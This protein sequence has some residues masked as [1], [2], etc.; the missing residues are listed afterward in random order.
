MTIDAPATAGV[1]LGCASSRSADNTRWSEVRIFRI[2][3]GYLA[4]RVGRSTV[5]GE[6]DLTASFGVADPRELVRWLSRPSGRGTRLPDVAAAAIAAASA[7]DSAFALGLAD[8]LEVEWYG[9]RVPSVGA[10]VVTLA[11]DG[12]RPVRFC[13]RIIGHAAARARRSSAASIFAVDDGTFAVAVTVDDVD[14]GRA[15]RRALAGLDA[16]G[17]VD[18]LRFRDGWTRVARRALRAAI[19]THERFAAAARADGAVHVDELPPPATILRDGPR[20]V[21]FVG[22]RIATA[23]TSAAD[24]TDTIALYKQHGGGYVAGVLTRT[25]ATAR[26]AP[27]VRAFE[28]AQQLVHECLAWAPRLL[29]AAAKVDL[30]VELALSARGGDAVAPAG[31]PTSAGQRDVVDELLQRD[32]AQR[33]AGLP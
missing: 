25:T 8:E 12:G 1:P 20:Q 7:A 13:G 31:V 33:V 14:D 15:R 29:A 5:P 11:R 19:A 16:G 10:Q 22:T 23:R 21:R 2:G 26:E 24:R 17:V 27:R 28:S 3:N 6:V 4:E 30:E 9:C 18:A 32:R